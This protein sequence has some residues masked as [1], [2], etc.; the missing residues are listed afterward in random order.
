[1]ELENPTGADLLGDL[2]VAV[3]D[4]LLDHTTWDE[5]HPRLFHL[6]LIL[7]I[8]Y[9]AIRCLIEVIKLYRQ[10]RFM[11]ELSNLMK[12]LENLRFRQH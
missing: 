10:R 3:L 9:Y 7:P 4:G 2:I 6:I 5:N 11:D 8:A 1:M 12:K